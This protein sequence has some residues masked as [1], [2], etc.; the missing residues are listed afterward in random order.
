VQ[1][2]GIEENKEIVR[3]FIEKVQNNQT[4][5]PTTNSTP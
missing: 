3:R 2:S 1:T 5:T 4:G